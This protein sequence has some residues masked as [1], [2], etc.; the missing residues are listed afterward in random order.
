MILHYFT[1]IWILFPR[2]LFAEEKASSDDKFEVVFQ[3]DGGWSTDE[4]MEYKNEKTPIPFLNEFTTCYW[5]RLRY[6]SAD[7]VSVWQYCGVDSVANKKI[8][9]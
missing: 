1:S 4:W 2:F 7:Y 6:F 9:R 3:K 5:D 8:P